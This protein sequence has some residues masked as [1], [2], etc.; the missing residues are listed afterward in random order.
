MPKN[1]Q[2]VVLKMISTSSCLEG[3][4]LIGCSYVYSIC[5]ES[6]LDYT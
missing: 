3:C 4:E 1:S 6:L 2:Q 5:K